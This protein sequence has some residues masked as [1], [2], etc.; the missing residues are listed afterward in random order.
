MT[1]GKIS[2]SF[3]LTRL[4]LS[5]RRGVQEPGEPVIGF[6][7]PRF[8]WLVPSKRNHH[9]SDHD[10]SHTTRHLVKQF[11][12]NPEPLPTVTVLLHFAVKLPIILMPQIAMCAN[13]EKFHAF[14]VYIKVC[15]VIYQESREISTSTYEIGL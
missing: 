6:R 11:L 10:G 9:G 13:N 15:P 3:G 4:S 7:F 1:P 14:Y 8:D 5:V 12:R 2:S